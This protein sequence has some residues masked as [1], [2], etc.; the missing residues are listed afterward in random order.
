ME[1]MSEVLY[2]YVINVNLRKFWVQSC[3]K[4]CGSNVSSNMHLFY[5]RV[6]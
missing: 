5:S 1:R 6:R 3:H 4:E 2:I